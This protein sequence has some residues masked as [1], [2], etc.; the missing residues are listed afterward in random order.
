MTKAET[1]RALAELLGEIAVHSNKD[2]DQ[3]RNFPDDMLELIHS[4]AIEAID[5]TT[6]LR[7]HAQEADHADL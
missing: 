3:A 4:W 2:W 5:L 6:A 7:A 1:L